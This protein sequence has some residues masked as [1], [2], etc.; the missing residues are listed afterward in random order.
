MIMKVLYDLRKGT[1]RQLPFLRYPSLRLLHRSPGHSCC[2]N[3]T[4]LPET[5]GRHYQSR[6]F[7]RLLHRLLARA[8]CPRRPILFLTWRASD[9]IHHSR[10]LCHLKT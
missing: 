7:L 2:L 5:S 10:H 8:Q 9:P 4:V 1:I 3:T 6:Q